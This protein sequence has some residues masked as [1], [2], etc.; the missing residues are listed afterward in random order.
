MSQVK[1]LIVLG[2]CYDNRRLTNVET[3]LNS[4][5]H[6]ATFSSAA[7]IDSGKGGICAVP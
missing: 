4:W 7:H 2:I 5:E 1:E 3:E 6:K